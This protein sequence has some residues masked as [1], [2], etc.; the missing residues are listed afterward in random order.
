M[1]CL[2]LARNGA[3]ADGQVTLTDLQPCSRGFVASFPSG[4][5]GDLDLY[6]PAYSA[7]LGKE[8]DPPD[9][10]LLL[11]VWDDDDRQRLLNHP[12][13]T[14]GT[15]WA[16][17][18]ARVVEVS[19]GP[20]EIEEWARKGLQEKYP[21]L[22]LANV[23]VLTFGHGSTPTAERVRSAWQYGIVELLFGAAILGLWAFLASRRTV[24]PAVSPDSRLT[25]AEVDRNNG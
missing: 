7:G 18:G 3:P 5:Y 24:H 16:R 25:D 8:P 13:P 15:C 14:E 6:I 1:T 17:K 22:R 11:Q 20:G 2:E 10:A 21:G 9:L 4:E 19:R 12:G 23:W